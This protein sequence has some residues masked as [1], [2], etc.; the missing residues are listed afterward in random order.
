MNNYISLIL[1]FSYSI[2]RI[3]TTILLAQTVDTVFTS[4]GRITSIELLKNNQGEIFILD[5]SIGIVKSLDFGQT[6]IFALYDSTTPELY[7]ISFDQKYT[8]IGFSAGFDGLYKTI[9]GGYNWFNTN[10]FEFIYTVDVNP[11]L[12]SIIFAQ[13]AGDSGFGPFYLYSSIDKGETWEESSI[14]RFVLNPQFH[15][16]NDTVAYGFD[17][18]NILRTDNLGKTW[19][20]IKTSK[21]QF[22]AMSLS[23]NDPETLYASERGLLFKTSN[24]GKNWSEIGSTLRG[25]VPSFDIRCMLLNDSISERI[26]LGLFE[27][28]FLTE[29]DGL[30]WKQI[31]KE[32]VYL[33]TADG[34]T[35]RNIYFTTNYERTALRIVDSLSVTT[36]HKENTI[37]SK[38]YFLFQNYPNPFNPITKISYY[39]KAKNHVQLKIFDI[40]G[41]EIKTLVNQNQI[42]G[43]HNI[44][45]NAHGLVSGVYIYKLKTDSFEES[46]KMLLLQ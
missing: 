17:S 34:D 3:D 10:Q 5:E 11:Y 19:K 24:G 8:Q 31:Y 1:L 15:S 43:H 33:I 25:L 2:M 4:T 39:L 22:T 35:P 36:I 16:G 7:D 23:K 45:F 9:D 21:S 13:K 40:S 20:S 44:T 29:D 46:R 27:G 38:K 26:Y 30:N 12:S 28:L 41:K 14:E 37:P 6:W 18:Y 32:P 42:S